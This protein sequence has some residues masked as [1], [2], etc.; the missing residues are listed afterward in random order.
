MKVLFIHDNIPDYLCAGLFHGL[1]T[2]LGR[3]CLDLPRFD[4]MYKSMTL[5]TK[6]KIRGNAF[7]LYGLLDEMP[8]LMEDRFFIW[9]KNIKE[10]DYY[11]IADI[12]NCWPTY[13]RLSKI[14][15]PEKIIII[16]PSDSLRVFPFNNFKSDIKI[17]L[18]NLIN[19]IS[20]KTK[21]FKREISISNQDKFG[22]PL[23]VSNILS[24]IFN[25]NK[26]FP[27][28]FSIPD[29]KI[30]LSNISEKVKLFTNIIVDEELKN[31]NQ[32]SVYLQ[33]NTSNYY[34]T[35]EDEYYKDIQISKFGVTTKRAGWDCLRHYEYAANGAVLCFKD[36][37]K[38]Y[39]ECAPFGLNDTNCII[40]NNKEHLISQI[41]CLS[42]DQ[43]QVLLTNTFNWV[44]SK[45]TVA[46][47]NQFMADL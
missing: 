42:D 10:F 18:L 4:C 13:M 15:P 45:S 17:N 24:H 36:L 23:F 40:Y 37:N 29:E 38:K 2:I 1:R 47:A 22:L 35:E 8:E 14:I 46:V 3:D 5:G 21:Y 7:S 25:K 33:L 11:I 32:S 39:F 27:I 19:G 12:W 26:L 43:Y 34:Y 30:R 44:K 28:S 31:I 20:S 16:D 6:N 9:H 41:D